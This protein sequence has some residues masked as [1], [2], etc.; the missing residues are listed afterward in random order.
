MKRDMPGQYSL[1]HVLLIADKILKTERYNNHLYAHKKAPLNPEAGWSFL[2]EEG[3]AFRVSCHIT[4]NCRI[5]WQR[6]LNMYWSAGCGASAECGVYAE[7]EDTAPWGAY[8]LLGKETS[9]SLQQWCD[10]GHGHTEMQWEHM[11]RQ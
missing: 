9:S 8:S 5:F 6:S 4:E 10:D 1:K 2:N 3:L 7:E 11:D